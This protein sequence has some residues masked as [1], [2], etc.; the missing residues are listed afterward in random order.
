MIEC[1]EVIFQVHKEVLMASSDVFEAMFNPEMKEGRDSFVQIADTEPEIFEQFLL[2]IY[3]EKCFFTEMSKE[4]VEGLLLVA[5][6]YNIA[7]LKEKCEKELS[8]R[9]TVD[10]FGSLAQFATKYNANLLRSKVKDFV[11][12][13]MNGVVK[14][15]EE[16]EKL[17]DDIAKEAFFAAGSKEKYVRKYGRY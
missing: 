15:D 16:W 13:N 5:D 8:G 14:S 6:K 7:S 11:S 1:K 4:M 9:L 2:F 12:D 3:T 17:P 10:N